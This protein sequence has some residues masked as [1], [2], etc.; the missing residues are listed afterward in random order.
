[1]TPI[2]LTPGDLALAAT[3]LIVAAALSYRHHL[4]LE[5]SLA[6]AAVR[7][8]V[9]LLLVGIVLKFVFE[10]T[11]LWTTVAVALAMVT[12]AGYEATNRVN[13]P[14]LRWRLWGLGT[15][16]L[17]VVGLL[18]TFFAVVVVIGPEPWHAPR[19]LLP[20][21]G[22]VLG[23]ALTA[24]SLVTQTMATIAVRDRR[25]I[26]G[27]LALGASRYKA[28]SA[29]TRE[30]L[31]TGL[32]PIINAMAVSGVVSLPGMM[33]GQVIAGVDPIEA[34]KYQIVIMFVLSG[35]VALAAYAGAIGA[36]SLLTDNRHRLRL[37][38][39]GDDRSR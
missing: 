17:L 3:L 27:Q 21:L 22:M 15:G 4:E 30:A 14:S 38:R 12:F 1:M 34:A 20:I 19:Y 25:A 9:Q 6:I 18:A 7:M 13:A 10:Q 29:P 23:N 39:L 8:V 26:D 35:A 32:T 33:T 31:R 28:L 5:R 24:V 36:V 11:S 16:T 2:R 37:D